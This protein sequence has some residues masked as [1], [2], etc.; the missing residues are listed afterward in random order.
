M[1]Y[2]LYTYNIQFLNKEKELPRY[3]WNIVESGVIHH[4]LYPPLEKEFIG[5]K[6]RCDAHTWSTNKM[7]EKYR[8]QRC[9]SWQRN[10]LLEFGT[11]PL[12]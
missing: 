7:V 1:T 12:L 9:L 3:N 10:I 11:G 2:I 8:I 4:N 5:I 6:W